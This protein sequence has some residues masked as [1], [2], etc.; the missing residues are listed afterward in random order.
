[1]LEGEERRLLSMRPGI[2]G[3][4]TLYFRDEESLLSECDDPEAYNRDVVFPK[5]VKL[6]LDYL[7]NYSFREDLRLIW[8]TATG[9]SYADLYGDTQMENE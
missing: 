3:P 1:M 2:T 7:D 5:K 4:A 8:A 9:K 6:N